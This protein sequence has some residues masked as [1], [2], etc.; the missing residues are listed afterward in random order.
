M[1]D[2]CLNIESVPIFEKG[3]KGGSN[4]YSVH[5]DPSHLPV[6]LVGTRLNYPIDAMSHLQVGKFN[7]TQSTNVT[8]QQ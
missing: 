8:N 3:E 7:T 6:T 5:H 4:F 2:E 1:E